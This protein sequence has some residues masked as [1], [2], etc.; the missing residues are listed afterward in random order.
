MATIAHLIAPSLAPSL[1]APPPTREIPS[2]FVA[3]IKSWWEA[4]T[5]ASTHAEGRLLRYVPTTR[6]SSSHPFLTYPHR[7]LSYY[8]YEPPQS[9]AEVSDQPVIAYS[10][11]IVLDDQKCHINTLSITSTSPCN[12]SPAPAVLLHGY[13][14]GLGFFFKNFSALG[15]WAASRRSSVYAID[16]LGMGRSARVP[17]VVNAKRDD[18]PG[19]VREAEAFFVDSLEEWREKMK[20][21][22]MTLVGHSLGAYMSVAYALKYPTRVSRLVLLSP[23]GVPRDPNTTVPSRE[24]TDDQTIEA[25][26]V[27]VNDAQ[28]ATKAKVE[29]IKSEQRNQGRRQG[30][31]WKVFTYLW[32]EGWS[33]FQVVRSAMWYGPI[34]VGKYSSRRFPG[35]TE[36]EVREM[37]DYILNITL[38]KGSG[39][40]CIC[41]W[42]PSLLGVPF[43]DSR[44]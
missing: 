3:G 39:E 36:E 22:K 41:E 2:T 43:V 7:K 40:Y 4:G 35:F 42:L 13:G 20:L 27:S 23:A 38:A 9:L 31:L 14:A 37:H 34:L 32:E 25:G 24:V 30:R 6:P 15:E 17:F 44:I 5:S 29:E 18:I 26:Y 8:R 1:K 11:K 28:L 10:S 21:E 33:P 12:S 19:R 16:W